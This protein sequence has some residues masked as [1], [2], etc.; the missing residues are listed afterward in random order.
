MRSRECFSTI[1]AVSRVRAAGEQINT[2]SSSFSEA[3]LF[4]ICSAASRPRPFRGRSKSAR[5]SSFQLDLACRKRYK[6]RCTF[7]YSCNTIEIGS[8]AD[9]FLRTPSISRQ[10]LRRRRHRRQWQVDPARTALSMAKSRRLSGFFL[11]VELVAAGQ[12]YDKTGQEASPVY[13][14]DLL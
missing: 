7:L 12:G 5:E 13:T 14:R 2:A 11:R 9:D 3:S 4:P 10:T 6:I 1:C 8:D